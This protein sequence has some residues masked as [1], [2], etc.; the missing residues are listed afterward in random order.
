MDAV[1]VGVAEA[2]FDLR[3]GSDVG[4]KSDGVPDIERGQKF[5]HGFEVGTRH[6]DFDRAIGREA[7]SNSIG[8]AFGELV[9][10]DDMIPSDDRWPGTERTQLHDGEG[11]ESGVVATRGESRC[12]DTNCLIQTHGS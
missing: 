6:D 11:G 9:E 3:G 4:R 10:C 2:C 7:V 8:N 1:G 12:N 5:D